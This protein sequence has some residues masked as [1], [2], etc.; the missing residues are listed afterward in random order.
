M[1]VG[2]LLL[3]RQRVEHADG[4]LRRVV[5]TG[6]KHRQVGGTANLQG[7]GDEADR[8]GVED[9][10]VVTLLQDLHRTHE[11]LAGQQ[12]RR[13][14]GHRTGQEQVEVLVEARGLHLAHH[15]ALGDLARR[16]QRRDTHRAVGDAEETAQGGLA[17]VETAEDDLLAQQRQRHGEVG[18]AERLTLTRRRGR[19]QDGML[20]LLQHELDVGAHRTEDLVDLIVLVGLHHD[21]G[22]ALHLVAGHRH[23]GD[24]RQVGEASQVLMA[25]NLEAEEA[26]EE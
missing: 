22:L 11:V 15:V 13:V 8:G 9:D 19:E 4:G 17:D 6:D 1:G 26:D 2:H 5:G 23:V 21:A 3:L 25:F 24:D 18:G 20:A 12:L 16:E 7:I 10:V 14:R